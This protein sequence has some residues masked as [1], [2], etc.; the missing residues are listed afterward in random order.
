MVLA[1]WALFGYHAQVSFPSPCAEPFYLPCLCT[2][3][4]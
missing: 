2:Q 3:P 4:A 1:C